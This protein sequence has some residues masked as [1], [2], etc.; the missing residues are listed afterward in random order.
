MPFFLSQLSDETVPAG[1]GRNDKSDVLDVEVE[2]PFSASTRQTFT[3]NPRSRHVT[4]RPTWLES[5]LRKMSCPFQAP[6]TEDL[7]S[8]LDDAITRLLIVPSTSSY[9]DAVINL[10]VW[11]CHRP[12]QPRQS[13]LKEV[14]DLKSQFWAK[15]VC[16]CGIWKKPSFSPN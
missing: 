12:V 5:S 8:T 3:L 13:R 6:S 9:S 11:A 10:P 4:C 16:H 7:S 2:L 14:S 15:N 1:M